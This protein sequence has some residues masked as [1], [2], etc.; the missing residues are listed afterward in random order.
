MRYLADLLTSTR[1]ILAI[2]LLV[3]AFT[4]GSP[5]AAFIIFIVAELTDS[6]DGTCAMKWPFP[7]DKAPSYRKYAAKYDIFADGVLTAA[8]VLYLMLQIN[9][10]IGVVIAVIFL[11]ASSIIEFVVYGKIMGHPDDCT[12]NSLIRRNFL[13]AKKIILI[14]RTIYEVCLVVI[15]LIILFATDWPDG[16][17]YGIAAAYGVAM[18]II[19]FFQGQRRKY[20][21]RDAV[22]IEEKLAASAKSSHKH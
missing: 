11:V 6:V 4:G 16:V 9:W 17:K 20:I 13:L 18:I 19:W 12:K 5:E 10:I 14:R 7:K 3:L 2:V 1:L 22:D 21:S 15:A 8:V